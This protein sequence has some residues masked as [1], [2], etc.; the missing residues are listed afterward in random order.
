MSQFS[1][2]IQ[3]LRETKTGQEAAMYPAIRD[4]FAL[5]LAYERKKILTDIAGDAGDVASIR[6]DMTTDPFLKNIEPRYPSSANC[7]HG[8]RTGLDSSERYN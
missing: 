7:I 8:F 3:I 6:V 4:V 5:G 1:E 2:A